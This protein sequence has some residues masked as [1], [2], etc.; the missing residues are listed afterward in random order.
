MFNNFCHLVSWVPDSTTCA[1]ISH[2][3][4]GCRNGQGS[5][6]PVMNGACSKSWISNLEVQILSNFPVEVYWGFARKSPPRWWY[7]WKAS[8]LIDACNRKL[9]LG[10]IYIERRRPVQSTAS[11]RGG[12]S[13]KCV[14]FF[15]LRATARIWPR[16]CAL[17]AR[18]RAVW[19][20]T[21][22]GLSVVLVDGIRNA[23]LGAASRIHTLSILTGLF[24]KDI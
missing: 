11:D 4:F 12:I 22:S 15:D 17:F 1:F 16:I 6:N 21:A 23:F 3:S 8:I 19:T 10:R 20:R 9:C 2:R 18:Q 24:M 7:L 14:K 13:L 5:Q